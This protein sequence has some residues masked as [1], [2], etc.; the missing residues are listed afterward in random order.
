MIFIGVEL[1]FNFFGCKLRINCKLIFLPLI[2]FNLNKKIFILS[3]LGIFALNIS[4]YSFKFKISLFFF[5]LSNSWNNGRWC[6][7]MILWYG[8]VICLISRIYTWYKKRRNLFLTVFLKL[9]R[10]ELFLNLIITF[11]FKFFLAL[12]FHIK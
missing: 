11:L 1:L 6:F 3:L 4:N 12:V 2:I 8:L 7:I 9:I 5:L 10:L